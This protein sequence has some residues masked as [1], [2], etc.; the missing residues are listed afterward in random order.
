MGTNPGKNVQHAAHPPE[1]LVLVAVYKKC[2]GFFLK[3]E[4]LKKKYF[5]FSRKH[6]HIF[7]KQILQKN[8]QWDVHPHAHFFQDLFQTPVFF[9][10]LILKT[11]KIQCQKKPR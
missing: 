11:K 8:V 2:A 10:N 1:H 4:K 6:L 7:R 9:L 5:L 3:R